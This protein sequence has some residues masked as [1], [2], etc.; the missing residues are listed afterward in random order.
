MCSKKVFIEDEIL[1]LIELYIE[2]Y[3]VESEKGFK[4]LEERKNR[5]N[6]LNSGIFEIIQDGA[7][8]LG[9]EV[10]EVV[11]VIRECI[12]EKELNPEI[13]ANFSEEYNLLRQALKGLERKEQL[14]K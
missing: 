11:D 6:I 3:M 9:I 13:K 10:S 1:K 2:T 8:H 14:E 7:E 5:L 4:T 12:D